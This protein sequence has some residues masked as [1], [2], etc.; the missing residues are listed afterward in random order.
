MGK[1][2]IF[3]ANLPIK[4]SHQSITEYCFYWGREEIKSKILKVYFKNFSSYNCVNIYKE[5][6]VIHKQHGIHGFRKIQ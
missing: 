4:V 5:N 6:A 2:F 3:F 1:E